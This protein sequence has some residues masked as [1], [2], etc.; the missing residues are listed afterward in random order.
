[1]FKQFSKNYTEEIEVAIQYINLPE[2][3]VL[4]INNSDQTIK[5][6]LNGNGFRL[7]KYSWKKPMIQLDIADATTS[8]DNMYYFSLDDK[9][10][11]L[12]NKLN[13]R[14]NVLSKKKDSLQVQLDINL[15]KKVPVK[16]IKDV[17]YAAGYGSDL[18]VLASPDSV[19]VMG[20]KSIIDTLEQVYST[21]LLLE[22]LHADHVSQLLIDTVGLPKSI[23]VKPKEIEIT[24][25]VSK[26]TEGSKD[27]PITLKNVPE[28]K[29]IKIF[30][31]QVTV[32][33]RVGLDAYNKINQKDF[34]VI[35]D[36]KKVA[37]NSSFLTLE[38]VNTPISIHDV[39]LRNKQVQYVILDK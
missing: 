16:I 30:P 2:D 38:L 23:E 6:M 24:I 32:V 26:F 35:A 18:G 5:L 11:L 8:K 19:Y 14:G 4:N 36:Y 1:M 31:K 27:I 34:K 39:R 29:Q 33:Y 7:V 28:G 37:E 9:A 10:E 25:D 21:N 22:D 13:F 12:K 15:Q 3:K 20:P 17:S